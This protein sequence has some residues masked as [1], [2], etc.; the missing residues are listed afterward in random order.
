MRKY[1][2]LL[3]L[4]ILLF[5]YNVSHA[6]KYLLPDTAFSHYLTNHY[7]FCMDGDSLITD[8]ITLSP[9]TIL[10]VYNL[11]IKDLSGIGYFTTLNE[12]NC[13]ANQLTTLPALPP[14][15]KNLYCY[16]NQL[17]VLPTLPPLLE[18][19]ACGDNILGQLPSFPPSVRTIDC[20][21]NFLDSL[22]PLPD[23]LYSLLCGDN[24]LHKLPP[25]PQK[26]SYLST[27]LN[28]ISVLPVLPASLKYFH[29]G[30]NSM[31]T[32][33]ALPDGL[34]ELDCNYNYISSLPALPSELQSLSFNSNAVQAIPT[35]P[36]G[37]MILHCKDNKL[38]F[39][40]IIPVISIATIEYA[41]Q[42]SI[43]LTNW[44]TLNSGSDFFVDATAGYNTYNAYTWYKNNNQILSSGTRVH[45]STDLFMISPIQL[46]DS[47]SYYCRV[48]NTMAPDLTLY[49][50]K[51]YLKVTGTDAI[52]SLS[53]HTASGLSAE[54]YPNPAAEFI[55]INNTSDETIN[56]QF[57][58]LQG[59]KLWEENINTASGRILSITEYKKGVYLLLLKN[60]KQKFCEKIILE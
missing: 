10:N 41:P 16:A 22:P 48:T 51:T 23:S 34:L 29:C 31:Y 17:S 4:I 2:N 5:Q 12:L 43:G 47:G 55:H 38:D 7:S 24:L 33:P 11:K 52:S 53:I 39:A 15:L 13:Y 50:R 60:E 26:L 42:D 44:V 28:D 30:L 58:D 1:Y 32:L 21:Y 14:S 25:L 59:R 57:I 46:A 8:S 56:A 18:Y 27:Y 19:L 6:Q 45:A 40:D 9:I 37:V 54:V 35:L 36:A 49:N 20:Q 3:C